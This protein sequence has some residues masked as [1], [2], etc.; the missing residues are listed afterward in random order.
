MLKGIKPKA[1]YSLEINGKKVSS[2]TTVNEKKQE[3]IFPFL[4]R[5]IIPKATYSVEINKGQS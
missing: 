5:K 1:E 2:G 4:K 3:V